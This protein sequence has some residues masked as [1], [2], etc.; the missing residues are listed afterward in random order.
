M[1]ALERSCLSSEFACISYASV[2]T[3]LTALR[4]KAAI[5]T[6]YCKLANVILQVLCE[7]PLLTPGMG[8]RRWGVAWLDSRGGSEALHCCTRS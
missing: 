4:L 7:P 6:L 2:G 5:T 8:R 1:I 3:E